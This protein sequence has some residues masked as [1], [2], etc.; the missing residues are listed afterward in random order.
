MATPAIAHADSSTSGYSALAAQWWPWAVDEPAPL[1]PVNDRTGAQCAN[2]QTGNVWFL[3]G[4]IDNSAVN[5]TCSVPGGQSLFFPVA[6]AFECANPGQVATFAQE[7]SKA[8][9]DFTAL[10][11]SGTKYTVTVDGKPLPATSI[12]WTQSQ[13]FTLKLPGNN[14][15]AAPA[16]TYTPCA[17]VGYYTLVAPLSAG[18]HTVQFGA[19][20]PSGSVLQNATYS[21]LVGN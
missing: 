7:Q 1:S 8:I 10:A 20:T 5:R 3:A 15:F 14:V 9:S 16:G 2:G 17:D 12:V 21:L 18:S 13:Q 11:P 19:T 4:T 6:D